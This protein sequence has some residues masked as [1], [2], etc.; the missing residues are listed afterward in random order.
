MAKSDSVKVS[1]AIGSSDIISSA[2][3]LNMDGDSSTGS[4]P[5]SF[6]AAA[7]SCSKS[8]SANVSSEKSSATGAAAALSVGAA[9][10]S[11]LKAA[12]SLPKSPKSSPKSSLN[13]SPPAAGSLEASA[14]SASDKISLSLISVV[15]VLEQAQMNKNKLAISNLIIRV[16]IHDPSCLAFNL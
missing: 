6:S 15:S 12:S 1:S 16:Y 11:S 9:L 4:S 2:G 14:N 13:S 7:N 5:K 3:S 10:G 8:S